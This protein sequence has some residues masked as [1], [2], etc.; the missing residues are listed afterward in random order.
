MFLLFLL[1][2]E[3]FIASKEDWHKI[4]GTCICAM[5]CGFV[6]IVDE[7]LYNMW[8][9]FLFSSCAPCRFIPGGGDEDYLTGV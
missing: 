7:V 4:R 3:H 6:W 8:I 9:Q 1:C 5:E 2:S